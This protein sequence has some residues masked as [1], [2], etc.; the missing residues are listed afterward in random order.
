MFNVL[1]ILLELVTILQSTSTLHY[2]VT[3]SLELLL[4]IYSCTQVLHFEIKNVLL[5]Y[6]LFIAGH[7]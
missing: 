7:A 6:W 4:N 2:N 5:A 1:K 3:A